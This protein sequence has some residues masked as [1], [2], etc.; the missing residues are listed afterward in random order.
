MQILTSKMAELNF[1]YIVSL[2]PYVLPLPIKEIDG[3]KCYVYLETDNC[4]CDETK[5]VRMVVSVDNCCNSSGNKIAKNQ[6]EFA[7]MIETLKHYK[8]NVINDM[9]VD[10]RKYTPP[11]KGIF[12]DL[13]SPTLKMLD[14][15]CVCLDMTRRTLQPCDHTICMRCVSR[16]NKMKCPMCRKDFQFED[17]V[18]DDD[19]DDDE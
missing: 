2:S 8:F 9:F 3:V 19:T 1:D 5:M 12:K 13:E 17:C 14:E 10:S 6:E 18:S 15:C 11:G 4:G 7:E 16:L